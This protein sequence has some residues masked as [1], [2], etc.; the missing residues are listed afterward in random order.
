[1]GAGPR[2]EIV[3][4]VAWVIFPIVPVLLEEI[5][6]HI[7]ITL[8]GSMRSGPDPIDWGW[9]TWVLMLGP[10]VGY[11]FLAGS[12][13]EVP[14]EAT[15]PRRSIHRLVARRAVWVAVGPWV[16][17]IVIIGSYFALGWLSNLLP[18]T[19]GEVDTDSSKQAPIIATLTW[20]WTVA[21]LGIAAYGWLW[22][23]WA[24]L[25]RAARV[26]LWRRA[27]YRGGITALAFVGSLFGS[28]WAIISAWR[29]F[30]CD[31]R[32]MPMIAMAMTL[33]VLSGCSSTITYGEM[34]RRELFHAMLSAWVFGLAVIWWWSSRGK[35]RRSRE[36]NSG[37]PRSS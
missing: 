9:G 19:Q 32:V 12:T 16:G 22:P 25:R 20:I 21:L 30:F 14:D 11:G 33:V 24:A 8:F 15:G 17:L 6:Y 35:S 2:A 37:S 31:P 13:A 5:Y 7:V 23:A 18:Q 10:L 28:F 36:G 26:G 4:A 29:R 1:M 27:L 34:R 3:M